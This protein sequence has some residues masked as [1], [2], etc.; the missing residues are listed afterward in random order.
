[1][2]QNSRAEPCVAMTDKNAS[3]SDRSQMAMRGVGCC[4]KIE[5]ALGNQSNNGPRFLPELYVVVGAFDALG[6]LACFVCSQ[7]DN[8]Q[9][10]GYVLVECNVLKKIFNENTKNP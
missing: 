1:M 6:C 7:L 8:D 5:C 2:E 10:K 4:A 3:K 9:G